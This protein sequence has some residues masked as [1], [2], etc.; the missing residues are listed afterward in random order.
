MSILHLRPNSDTSHEIGM[1]FGDLFVGSR[2][3]R[4]LQARF[5]DN[6][7]VK[8]GCHWKSFWQIST[9]IKKRRYIG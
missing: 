9:I 7:Q 3:F 4:D 5:L 2:T 6:F 1:T 8:T